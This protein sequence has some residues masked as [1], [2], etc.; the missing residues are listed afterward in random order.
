MP[1]PLGYL[2]D[3]L[4]LLRSIVRAKFSTKY[5]GKSAA[6]F[7]LAGLVPAIHAFERPK[8]RRRCAEQVRAR[9][10]GLVPGGAQP[11][12]WST[13][14]DASLCN[15]HIHGDV[16]RLRENRLYLRHLVPDADR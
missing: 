11:V 14:P 8:Q 1:P 9:Q 12:V 4:M 16:E 7:F 13:V 6:N 10:L 15:D 5:G 3:R 2:A